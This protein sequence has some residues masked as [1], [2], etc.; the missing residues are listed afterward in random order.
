MQYAGVG[1]RAVATV[2]DMALLFVLAYLVALVT[3][4]T[5]ATGF[6]LQGGPAFLTLGLW[7]VYYIALEALFGA[8]LGKRLLG[9]R[10]VKTDGAAM[11]WPAAIIRNVLRLVDG[12]V[13]Y[14]LGAILVWSSPH[15]Q[16]LGDRVAHT[17]VVQRPPQVQPAG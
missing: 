13:L 3:G 5:T 12:V 17:V 7:V 15:R 14:L 8:T 11:D 9:L 6:E 16:R 2:V 4:G 10:V 1:A